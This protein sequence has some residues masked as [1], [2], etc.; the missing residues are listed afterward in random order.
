M[1]LN[2]EIFGSQRETLAEGEVLS[3]EENFSCQGQ[4]SH[5][6]YAGKFK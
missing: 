2:N 4:I 3:L 5:Q 1:N 6:R